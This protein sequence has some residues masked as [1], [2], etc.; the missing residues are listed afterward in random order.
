MSC[1][2]VVLQ[3]A[4]LVSSLTESE[5]DPESY[6]RLLHLHGCLPFFFDA[7]SVYGLSE[8]DV[9]M[10]IFDAVNSLALSNHDVLLSAVS[11]DWLKWVLR[12]MAAWPESAEL[13]CE[14]IYALLVYSETDSFMPQI[15]YSP[16]YTLISA[17]MTR[18]GGEDSFVAGF[19]ANVESFLDVLRRYQQV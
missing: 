3:F 12:L 7:L 18:F 16:A 2:E 8:L 11:M 4:K 1:K 6:V 9:A 13:Q 5:E 10:S 14:A 15:V 17:A 19:R